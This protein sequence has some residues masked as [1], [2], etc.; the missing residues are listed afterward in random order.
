MTLLGRELVLLWQ[1]ML[2]AELEVKKLEFGPAVACYS[3]GRNLPVYWQ[4]VT[5]KWRWPSHGCQVQPLD[6]I[7]VMAQ[8]WRQVSAKYLPVLGQRWAV[9][10]FA[11]GWFQLITP[12]RREYVGGMSEDVEAKEVEESE[13]HEEM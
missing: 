10:D 1:T 12:L 13:S 2:E 5:G 7:S 3:A 4:P 9:C 11:L 8:Y 6:I